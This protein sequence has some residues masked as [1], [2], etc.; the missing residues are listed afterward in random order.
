MY[1]NIL[2]IKE[3]TEA[4]IDAVN[5]NVAREGICYIFILCC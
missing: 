2:I 4:K 3:L 1:I 5:L